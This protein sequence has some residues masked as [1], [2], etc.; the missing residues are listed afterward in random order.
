MNEPKK[1]EPLTKFY[2]LELILMCARDWMR[3]NYPTDDKEAWNSRYGLL[4]DFLT[5][6]F[7]DT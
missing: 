4:V 7:Q 2:S 1:V 6:H 3:E 5:D